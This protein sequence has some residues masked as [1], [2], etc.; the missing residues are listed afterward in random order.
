MCERTREKIENKDP[1]LGPGTFVN[2][3][4]E[5]DLKDVL[6]FI[7]ELKTLTEPKKENKIAIEEIYFTDIGNSIRFTQLHGHEARYCYREKTWYEYDGKRWKRDDTGRIYRMGKDVV[8]QLLK[9]ASEEKDDK[10]RMA[11]MEYAIRCESDAKIEAMLRASRSSLP[12]LP[13]DFDK[14][15][16]LFNCQNGTINLK[17]GEL[18]PHNPNDFI[19]KISPFEYKPGAICSHWLSHLIKIMAGNEKIIGFLKRW[20]GYCL[21]GSTDERKMLTY[22]GPGGNGKTLT[23]ETIAEAMGDYSYRAKTEILLVKRDNASSNDIACLVGSRFVYCSESE[24]GRRLDESLIKDLCGGD[25]IT[26][27]LLYQQNFQFNPTFKLNL[28]TNHRPIIREQ[29]RAIW[30]RI[31]LIPFDITISEEERRLKEEMMA[32]FREEGPG[33]LSWM[34]EGC[35]EWLNDGG[36][37]EPEEVK[38]ATKQYRIDMDLLEDFLTEHCDTED[39]NAQIPCH[40]VY[41]KYQEWAEKEGLRGKEVWTKTTLTKRLRERLFEQK[42]IK[43]SGTTVKFWI[44]LTLK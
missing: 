2:R 22:W 38:A 40:E 26:A 19:S 42:A 23:I 33:I 9:E 16:W 8:F 20:F 29:A 37:Q 41:K 14:D 1:L 11:L 32:E 35:L 24:E 44:G 21:S 25:T 43:V 34:V 39:K 10:R 15:R 17:T 36:L 28:S 3:A 12:I 30:D 4:K 6:R 18:L 13:E 31:R 27:R 5:E 7:K